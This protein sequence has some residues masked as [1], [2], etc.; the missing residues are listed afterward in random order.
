MKR[1]RTREVLI[2]EELRWRQQ[3]T[4]FW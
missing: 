4:W 2:A 1:S 3:E